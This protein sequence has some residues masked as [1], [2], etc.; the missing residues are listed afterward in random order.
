MAE[1]FVFHFRRGPQGR[2]E[3]MYMADVECRCGLCGHVQLQ[4]FYHATD[5]HSLT[6]EALEELADVAYEKA[7][8]ECENC[9]TAVGPDHVRKSALTYGFADDAGLIRI[10]DDMEAEVRRYQL[11]PQWRLDPQEIPRF[12]PD[13]EKGVE[14]EELDDAVLDRVLGR[15]LNIKEAWIELFEDWL[16]DP[17]G[18]AYA[19]FCPG[20]W[21]VID[22]SEELANQLTDEIEDEL[23]FEHDEH[24]DLMV[25]AL[26]DSVPQDLATH[27]HAETMHG[28]WQTWLPRH[29]GRALVEGNVWADAYISRRMTVEV[30]ERAFETARLNFEV[31]TTRADIFFSEITTPTGAIYGEG[32]SVSSVLRRAVYTGLSPG[33][34]ARLSAE[35]I[36]GVLLKVW[37]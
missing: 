22:E 37:K 30:L 34:A 29:V 8:Y 16:E 24:A 25:I 11:M 12:V 23:F 9:G 32:L 33:E 5:F 4:R 28:R 13:P 36:I 20:L 15:P 7:S 17:E 35:E 6:L 14:I 1:P 19:R 10:F 27:R 2:P 26:G 31:D 3:V 18:G 21:A